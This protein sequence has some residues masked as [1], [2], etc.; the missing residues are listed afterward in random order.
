MAGRPKTRARRKALAV[1][2]NGRIG[3][4]TGAAKARVLELAKQ[5]AA[6]MREGVEDVLT[7]PEAMAIIGS[8][9]AAET[10]TGGAAT[11]VAG[12]A[13][14]VGGIRYAGRRAARFKAKR[15]GGG[16]VKGSA[17]KRA[18]PKYGHVTM[19]SIED[20]NGVPVK[21]GDR[22][23]LG[24]HRHVH[25]ADVDSLADVVAIEAS[26]SSGRQ[27]ALVSGRSKGGAA[28]TGWLP[29]G[30]FVKASARP[31]PRR[32]PRRNLSTHRPLTRPIPGRVETLDE[33]RAR[34]AQGGGGAGARRAASLVAIAE[35]EARLA[36]RARGRRSAPRKNHHLRVGDRVR[37]TGSKLSGDVVRCG[38]RDVYVVHFDGHVQPSGWIDGRKL[39]PLRTNSKRP[40]TRRKS[41]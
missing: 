35:A 20:R 28:Y 7:D 32:K 12:A 31:N 30:A 11:P 19:S 23:K 6:Y 18:N 38:G 4:F 14:A 39:T 2:T 25:P 16:S 26:I 37:L 17:G 33:L 24:E 21:V 1:R 40:R 34:A 3:K 9:V 15:E 36:S 8:V 41:R 22:V 5:Q 29:G 27:T 13:L 10:A